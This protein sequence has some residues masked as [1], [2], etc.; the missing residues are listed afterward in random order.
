MYL[1]KT[2]NEVKVPGD[3]RTRPAPAGTDA[4]STEL[5]H[6]GSPRPLTPHVPCSFV[7]VDIIINLSTN[8]DAV[9]DST[10]FEKSELNQ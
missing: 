1:F 9:N 2:Y 10:T 6:L 8:V 5:Q 4:G 7:C 3:N